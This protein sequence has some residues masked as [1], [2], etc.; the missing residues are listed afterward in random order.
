MA[1]KKQRQEATKKRDKRSKIMLSVL[2][3]LLIAVGAYEIP[4]MLAVMNKKP[5]P[6]STYDPGPS[7]VVPGSLPNI[8]AGAPVAAAA[9]PKTGQLVNTDV[10]PSSAEGQ[11]VTFDVFDTKN[12]FRPQV[13]S[14]PD[15]ASTGVTS[16]PTTNHAPV[17]TVPA[18]TPPATTTTSTTT[19]P[20]STATGSIISSGPAA[21][22]QTPTT[23]A[24]PAAPTVTISVN[25]ASSRVEALGTFPT[26]SPVFR[27]MSYRH[28]SAE[29]GIVGGSYAAGGQA[30]TLQLGH[31]V[32]LENTTDGTRYRL[33]LLKTP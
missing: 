12:P 13:T 3:V 23:P 33:E 20:A 6:G 10:P 7:S 24:V 29:I 15:V 5:P 4:S 28:D 26:G 21:G 16:V 1:S 18:S 27:L 31:P 30:I 19:T 9:A 8:A 14:S 17:S 25:G 32:T 11:L 22:A 2:G